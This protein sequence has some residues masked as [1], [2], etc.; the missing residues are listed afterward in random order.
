[1][2]MKKEI[3]GLLVISLLGLLAGCGQEKTT[4]VIEDAPVTLRVVTM[5]GGT[6]PSAQVYEQIKEEYK[7]T[8]PNVVIEDESRTADE[9]WKSAVAADFCA[10]NEP[11]V[12]QFF[13]DATADQLVATKKFVSLEE[14]QKEYPQYAKDTKS[15]ALRQAANSD[16]VMR[17]VPTTGYWE[18]MYCNR[19]LFEKYDIPLPD[20]WDSFLYAVEKF[21]ENDIIPV[22]CS[23]TNVPHYWVEFLLLYTSGIKEYKMQQET[24]PADWV[25]ALETFQTLREIGAF[26]ENTDTVNNDYVVQLFQEK[27]AAMLLE[28]S[29]YLSSIIDQE[30][31]VIIPFPG[32][33]DQKVVPNTMVGGMTTGFYITR[34]AWKDEKR[35][36]AAVEYVMAHTSE[37]AVQR[38]WESLGAACAAATEVTAAKDL[39]PLADSARKYVENS[40]GT[41]LPT[42][43]RMNPAAYSK[44]ISGILNVSE[45]GS[46]EELLN[47]VFEI[48]RQSKKETE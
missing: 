20:D 31:T 26:P 29:W 25:K 38:Y 33:E 5:F 21:R 10:G 40:A 30:N 8:H 48:D 13:T 6:D 3:C 15:S 34:R 47:E 18:G 45:G 1:M 32:V 35:R 14:I 44:L 11:D 17:A 36:Q 23:L 2:K 4:V 24:V 41:V 28:G 43:A 12:L 42:D 27:K 19:D 9:E 39:T 16:D 22:A 46:A 37:A 7:E